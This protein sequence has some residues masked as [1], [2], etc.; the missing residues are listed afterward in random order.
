MDA[1][2]D[3]VRFREKETLKAVYNS[4]AEFSTIF[5]TSS[6]APPPS[7]SFIIKATLKLFWPFRMKTHHAVFVFYGGFDLEGFLKI[8]AW[9]R[10]VKMGTF[11]FLLI[12]QK[13]Q[14]SISNLIWMKFNCSRNEVISSPKRKLECVFIKERL[15]ITWFRTY[16]LAFL[17]LWDNFA[18]KET[19]SQAPCF[20]LR[21]TGS[22]IHSY[23][24]CNHIQ[25]ISR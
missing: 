19:S 23:F 9:K 6:P 11:D 7:L 8:F 18:V 4:K 15:F 1:F 13:C 16:H 21:S 2:N 20:T 25:S 17:P 22:S 10:N 14:H 24:S 12:A 3:Y 5:K